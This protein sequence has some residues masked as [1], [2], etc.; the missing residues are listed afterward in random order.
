MSNLNM[1][2]VESISLQKIVLIFLFAFFTAG[3]TA[4]A[5]EIIFRGYLVSIL[6]VHLSWK[7][8]ILIICVLFTMYHIPQW[9]LPLPYWIRY[10][11]MAIVFTLPVIITKSLWFSIGVHFGGNFTYYILLTELGLVVTEKNEYII[12]TMGWVSAIAA[13]LLLGFIYVFFKK[14]KRFI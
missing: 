3:F 6:K 8:I 9:G 12:E 7:W 5:E 11:I 14:F 4:F 2:S 13:L 10:F 1:I